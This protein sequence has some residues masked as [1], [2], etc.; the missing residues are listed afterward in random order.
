M[1]PY[2]WTSDETGLTNVN[3]SLF[4]LL[5]SDNDSN[6]DSDCKPNGYIIICRTFHTTMESDSDSN[7]NY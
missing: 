5:A 3:N 7:P 2:K 6:S 1:F 4:T